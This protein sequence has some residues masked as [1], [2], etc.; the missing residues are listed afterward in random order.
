MFIVE[1][2]ERITVVPVED[3]LV[4][5]LP[6]ALFMNGTSSGILLKST[7]FPSAPYAFVPEAV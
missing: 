3:V 2:L 4:E 7:D 1:P 6:A 5:E